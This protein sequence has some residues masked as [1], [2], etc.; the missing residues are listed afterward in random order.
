MTFQEEYK[1]MEGMEKD[2]IPELDVG[3]WYAIEDFEL[4]VKD[5]GVKPEWIIID[6]IIFKR[7]SAAEI[8]MLEEKEKVKKSNQSGV[9]RKQ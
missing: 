1:E 9:R 7:R 4:D 2:D 5:Y 8:K 6:N 3:S